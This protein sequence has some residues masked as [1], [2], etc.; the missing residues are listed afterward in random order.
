MGDTQKVTGFVES[1]R[2]DRKGIKLNGEWYSS[3]ST[4]NCNSR[5]NVELEFTQNGEWKNIKTIKVLSGYTNQKEDLND[6][7]LLSMQTSY[8]KDV[9]IALINTRG[10]IADFDLIESAKDSANAVKTITLELAI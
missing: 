3:F 10:N 1:V 6:A 9:L 7:K 8:A 4:V 2:K 5:D